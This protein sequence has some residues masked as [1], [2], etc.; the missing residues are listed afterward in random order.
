MTLKAME[1]ISGEITKSA[2]GTSKHKCKQNEKWLD[3]ECQNDL[4]RRS[5]LRIKSRRYEM[6]TSKQHKHTEIEDLRNYKEEQREYNEK[7]KK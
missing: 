5:L 1:V 2:D 7:T 4:E 3:E 6:T